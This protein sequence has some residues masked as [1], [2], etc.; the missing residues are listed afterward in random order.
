MTRQGSTLAFP[1]IVYHLGYPRQQEPSFIDF[2]RLII[3][4]LGSLTQVA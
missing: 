1:K 4:S 2:T 3:Y